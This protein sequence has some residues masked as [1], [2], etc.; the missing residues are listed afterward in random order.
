MTSIVCSLHGYSKGNMFEHQK[1]ITQDGN[2]I[3]KHKQ[4]VYILSVLN[5]VQQID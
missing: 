1:I 2:T 4:F 3:Y 5:T